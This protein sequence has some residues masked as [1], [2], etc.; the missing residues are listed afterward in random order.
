MAP[1]PPFGA[2]ITYW[3]D[4]VP[5]TGMEA[6]HETEKE[7]REQEA[8]IPFPGWET[9][10]TESMENGPMALLLIR[11]ADGEPVRWIQGPAREGLHRVNWDLRRPA[12]DPI[13]LNTGGFQPPWATDPQGPLAAP[14][15]YSAELFLAT[16]EGF[17]P[18]GDAQEF[19]VKP[20]P[21]APPGTDFAAVAAFQFQ[22][23][24]M[25]REMSGASEE[26]G[27]VRDRLRHMRAALV[28]TPKADPSLFVRVDEM[29]K[30][31][32]GL[33]L[34]FSGDRILGQWNMPS[35]P[36]IQGRVGYV[37]YGHWDTRLEPTATMRDNIAIAQR[38]FDA[39]LEELRSLVE[40]DLVNLE[41][42]LAAAG[43]PWTP[44]G[45][46]PEG[47]SSGRVSSPVLNRRDTCPLDIS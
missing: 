28:Q 25:A 2:L 13:E 1:N 46:F 32:E 20:V 35:V 24:E 11:D 43:A 31:L 14:G 23:S 45:A 7:L 39:F 19:R 40:V 33:N 15:S 26:M 27:R 10:R 12:P 47:E 37:Q 17:K 4:D 30:R 22:V 38:D 8:N 34:Q 3:L 42:D 41:D 5:E 44:G 21:T 36:S 18:V 9:L 6:R 16:D 29:S